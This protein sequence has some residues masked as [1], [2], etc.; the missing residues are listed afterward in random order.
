MNKINPLYILGFFI[1]VLFLMIYQNVKMQDKIVTATQQV[2]VVT[3]VGQE[4]AS[5]KKHW[6]NPIQ[7]K[8]NI[9]SI[10]NNRAFKTHVSKKE[11]K[12]NTY[13]IELKDVNVATLDKFMSKILNEYVILKKIK[14]ERLA[15]D[16]IKIA[17]ELEL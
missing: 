2:S 17:M 3:Q 14:I 13:K 15:E 4:I 12:S 7:A 8:K 16:K 1:F 9:D 5:L 6:K 10:L 11:K